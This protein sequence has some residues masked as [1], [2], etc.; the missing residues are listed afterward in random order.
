MQPLAVYGCKSKTL[1]KNEETRLDRFET[2]GL[3]KIL[4]VSWIAKKS[5]NELVLNNVGVKR[6]LLDTM[7]AMVTPRGICLMEKECKEQC[8]VHAGEEDHARSGWTTPRRG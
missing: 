5:T 3:R 1:R 6:E 8:Q 2:K 7:K 4:W